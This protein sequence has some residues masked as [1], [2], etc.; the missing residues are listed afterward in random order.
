LSN[1]SLLGQIFAYTFGGVE[2]IGNYA[3]LAAF[4]RPGT[5]NFIGSIVSTPFSFNP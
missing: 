3:W 2:P 1:Q 5:L 4:T